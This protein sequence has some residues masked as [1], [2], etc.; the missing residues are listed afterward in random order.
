MGRD[1]KKIR[2]WQKADDMVLKVYE[3]TETFPREEVYGLTSQ[4]RRAAVS[5][6]ANIVEGA[7]R[8]HKK[9]YLRFLD[10]ARSSLGEVD[11]YLHLSRRLGYLSAASYEEC[12]LVK[13]EVAKTLH[14]L[15]DAV[16]SEV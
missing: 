4:L 13:E 9:E 15:I 5:V 6:P 12:F 10:Y 7:S 2:A 14:G 8:N 1:F 16:K 3:I 11:Y